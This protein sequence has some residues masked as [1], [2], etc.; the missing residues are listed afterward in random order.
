MP[1]VVGLSVRKAV[2]A[3]ARHGIV[4]EIRGEGGTVIR[5]QPDAGLPVTAAEATGAKYVI[6]LGDNS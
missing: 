3:S 6:W 2:E 5:Q 4:P 1:V